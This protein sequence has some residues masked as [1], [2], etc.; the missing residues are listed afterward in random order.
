MTRPFAKT[1]ERKFTA[2]PPD[3]RGGATINGRPA[4]QVSEERK[5]EKPK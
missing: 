1:F 4:W 2:R 5:Q 3:S